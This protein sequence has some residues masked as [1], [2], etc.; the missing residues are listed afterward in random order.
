MWKVLQHIC[1]L[2]LARALKSQIKYHKYN[3][4]IRGYT[5]RSTAQALR[6]GVRLSLAAVLGRVAGRVAGDAVLGVQVNLG[7]VHGLA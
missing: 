1:S 2:Y 6:R 5:W 4:F 3:S 7:A